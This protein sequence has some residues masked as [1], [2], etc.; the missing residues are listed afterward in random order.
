MICITQI[1]LNKVRNMPV[2]DINL[3]SEARQHLILTGPNGSGKTT[4]IN[5]IKAY[6]VELN[7]NASFITMAAKDAKID[8]ISEWTKSPKYELYSLTIQ[9]QEKEL[10]E[11]GDVVLTIANQQDYYIQ[12][13]K[14]NF[15]IC[16]FD[17]SR[18]VSFIEPKG[19][20]KIQLKHSLDENVGQFFVQLLVNLKAQRSFARDDNNK[21]LIEKIDLWFNNFNSALATLLGHD[22]F[23]LVFDSV[24]FNYTIREKNKEP[25]H[26]SELSDGYSSLLSIVSE[27]MLRMSLDPLAAYNKEGIVLIDEI[28]NHL[29]VELQKKV[30]PFLSEFFPNIQFIVTTHSPFVL[31]SINNSVIFDMEKCQSF[32]DF[33]KYSYNS[34]IENYFGIDT[35]SDLAI[36]SVNEVE[37][38][39]SKD[40]LTNEDIAFIQKTK[41]SIEDLPEVQIVS[42]E[43]RV[44]LNSL[45]LNNI[46]K[47]NGLF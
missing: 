25:Y 31:S 47:L 6:F 9:R 26:F 13:L 34:I 14:N 12:Y 3:S 30:L 41:K 18:K 35:Y 28:E 7:K 19:V 46:S 27:L 15:I 24:D 16:S 43:L 23:E 29:H 44:K 42:P 33:S 40:E 39:L 2:V 5:A 22:D 8:D 37:R 45:L 32:E 4:L 11:S 17:S 21:E 1:R 20:S 38:L 36:E 10:I